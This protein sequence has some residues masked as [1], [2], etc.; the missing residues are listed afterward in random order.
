[1]LEAPSLLFG[2]S[3]LSLCPETAF[4]IRL[5]G[6][7]HQQSLAAPSRLVPGAQQKE[8]GAVRGRME[9]GQGGHGEEYPGCWG[10][11]RAA[12]CGAGT[13]Q[14]VWE[15]TGMLERSRGVARSHGSLGRAGICVGGW[16]RCREGDRVWA[17]STSGGSSGVCPQC[18]P[19]HC[20][21]SPP[22]PTGAQGWG[23]RMGSN[24]GLQRAGTLLG[25]CASRA[26]GGGG[27]LPHSPGLG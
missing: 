17:M 13:E 15:G 3:L 1:M 12:R 26:A 7:S 24:L 8:G 22:A 11:A 9:R 25:V 19:T 10:G 14:Q 20:L 23:W 21:W 27:S 2:C 16:G 18:T 6:G 4:S 5:A